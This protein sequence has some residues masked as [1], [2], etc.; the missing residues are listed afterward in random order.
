MGFADFAVGFAGGFANETVRQ[1]D[2]QADE[3]SRIV[4]LSL[5]SMADKAKTMSEVEREQE[6]LLRNASNLQRITGGAADTGTF[7]EELRLGLTPAQIIKNLEEN[8]NRYVPIGTGS[9]ATPTSTPAQT[10]F[11]IGAAAVSQFGGP[12][13][14]AATAMDFAIANRPTA[15]AANLGEQDIDLLTRTI[16]GEAASEPEQGQAAVASVVLNRLNSGQYGGTVR[17]VLFARNQF[18]P[19]T[20]AGTRERLM[21]ISMDSP[22]YQNARRVAEAVVSGQVQDFSQGALNFANPEVVRQY[23]DSGK[24]TP[25]TLSWVEDVAQNGVRIG[26]HVFGTPGNQPGAISPTDTQMADSGLANPTGTAPVQEPEQELS[27]FDRVRSGAQR[28]FGMDPESRQTRIQQQ[29]AAGRSAMGLDNVSN[30]GFAV[31]PSNFRINVGSGGVD[32]SKFPSIASADS[33]VKLDG[34]I[35][36]AEAKGLLEQEGADQW[37]I[38]VEARRGSLIG[39]LASSYM[40]DIKDSDTAANARNRAIADIEN[41]VIPQE[42]A[43][44]VLAAIDRTEQDL[45]NLNWNP[46]ASYDDAKTR[47]RVAVQT[48]DTAEIERLAPYLSALA[49][50]TDT[51][52]NVIVRPTDGSAGSMTPAKQ[53]FDPATAQYRYTTLDGQ[54]LD[55]DGSLIV[56]MNEEIRKAATAVQSDNQLSIMYREGTA[57]VGDL[58]RYVVPMYELAQ[59]MQDSPEVATYTASLALGI[60]RFFREANTMIGVLS[61]ASAERDITP[62]E[63]DSVLRQNGLLGD[64]E[65]LESVASTFESTAR[66]GVIADIADAR[67]A[68]EAYILLGTF[69]TG[70]IEGQEGRAVSNKLFE[71]L[72]GFMRNARNDGQLRDRVRIQIDGMA[73]QIDQTAGSIN[74][75]PQV[76]GFV[77]EYGYNPMAFGTLSDVMAADPVLAEATNYFLS[78]PVR[79][80]ANS[81]PAQTQE[82]TVQ[83][84]P[85]VPRAA[86]DYLNQNADNP[87]ILRAFEEKYG[88]SAGQYLGGGQ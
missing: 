83:D 17:D 38:A 55:A 5:T 3:D 43:E 4:E 11:D 36:E 59:L 19:W 23:A 28:L 30:E 44:G 88:V 73:R 26:N 57:A 33:L 54:P 63:A 1:K 68:Y 40:E 21:N 61:R 47:S 84:T 65:T 12:T 15:P 37:V 20:D 53:V 14:Q 71:E 49:P 35:A 69:R 32:L 10:N 9:T 13:K 56:P 41:G 66:T 27:G 81:Q 70:G 48:Q 42:A 18:Q 16:I 72:Q 6:T 60:D 46:P 34:A 50:A 74:N 85:Q 45:S 39:R 22:E 82:E 80:G 62:Q 8:P 52:T 2:R 29:V 7:F 58:S 75:H 31:P 79:G 87:T 67:R 51:V 77:R 76:R 78:A 86:I 25:A 64:G 24:A